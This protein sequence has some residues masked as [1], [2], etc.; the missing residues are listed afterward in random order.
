MFFCIVYLWTHYIKSA[1]DKTR[2]HRV[3]CGEKSNTLRNVVL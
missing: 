1:T 3:V 2:W